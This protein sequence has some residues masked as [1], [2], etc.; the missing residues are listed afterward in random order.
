ML[1]K[2]E[3]K[4]GHYYPPQEGDTAPLG[5]EGVKHTKVEIKGGSRE[6]TSKEGSPLERLQE[7]ERHKS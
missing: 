5:A 1:S 2:Q 7:A 6:G 4:K 3:R